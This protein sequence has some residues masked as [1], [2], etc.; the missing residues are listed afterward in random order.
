MSGFS[1]ISSFQKNYEL[2]SLV[3][4]QSSELNEAS[5]ELSTGLKEDVFTDS[6]GAAGES[7]SLRGL[8]KANDAFLQ[9][10]ALLSGRMDATVDSMTD[11]RSEATAFLN[12]LIS[13]S[14][15]GSNKDVLTTQ[16][17]SSIE[18]IS[19]RLNS[20]YAGAYLFSGQATDTPAS[21]LNPDWTV[22]YT[23][24]STGNLSARI[25]EETTLVYGVRGDDPGMVGITTALSDFAAIDLS[26]LTQAQFETLRDSTISILGEGLEKLTQ[27]ESQLGGKQ[28]L[29]ERTVERQLGLRSLYNDG[30]LGIE[31]V[32]AHEAAIRLNSISDQLEATYAVTARM[33]KM[34]LLNYL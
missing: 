13:G 33:S 26:T 7:L 5:M 15:S 3:A 9:S 17:Q 22:T 20:T 12:L 4:K 28:G 31:G 6:R 10:N 8:T 24:D 25:D 19:N 32:D 18:Q 11:I 23:G 21:V 2:R 30:I 34:S 29:L 14:A 16:A 1:T 27:A